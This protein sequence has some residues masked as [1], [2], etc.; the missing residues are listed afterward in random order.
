MVGFPEFFLLLFPSFFHSLPF[1]SPFIF[2]KSKF[3]HPFRLPSPTVVSLCLY[4]CLFL[5]TPILG[6][7]VVFHFYYDF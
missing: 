6:L 5:S 7:V 3:L 1:P 2:P 4:T